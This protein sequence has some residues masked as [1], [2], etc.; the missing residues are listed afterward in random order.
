MGVSVRQTHGSPQTALRAHNQRS[1]ILPASQPIHQWTPSRLAR[2]LL[3]ILA[4]VGLVLSPVPVEAKRDYFRSG[5]PVVVAAEPDAAQAGMNVLKRGGS[6]IDAAVAVQ[7]ALSLLEPQSSGIGGGAFLLYYDARSGKVTAYNG[8]ETA[9]A[10]ADGN[11][12]MDNDGRPLSFASAVV[13]GRATGVPGAMFMLERAHRDHGRLPWRSLF[14]DSI[15][16]AEQGFHVPPRLAR[17]LHSGPFP[18]LRSSD[19]QR[20]F[21]NGKGGFVRTGDLLKNPEYGRTLRDIAR[22][23]MV[24]FRE[25]PLAQEIVD[26]LSEAPLPSGMR[27]SDLQSYQP[28]VDEAACRTYRIHVVCVPPSP[29]GGVSVLQGLQLLERFPI[30]S[31]GKD[32]PRSWA[33]FIE[34]LRLMYADRDQYVGDPDFVSVPMEG[35]LDPSYIAARAAM[36]T[37]GKASPVPKPGI[38]TGAPKLLLDKTLEPG[39]TTHFVVIDRYGNAVSMTTT[40]ESLFGTGRM[41]GG[42]FLNN[43]LTDFSFSPMAADGL[44]AANAV[45]PGKRPRSAMSPI[46]VFDRSG[47]LQ[48]L[49][50]SPG[51]PAIIS[52]NLKALIGI[53]DWQLSMQ[54]AIDL[55]N[56]VAR[57]ESIRIEARR[58]DPAIR[59]SLVAMGYVLTEVQ[60]EESGLN[61][62][63]RQ[64]DGTFD[65][66]VDPRRNGV[67]VNH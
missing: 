61:G 54:E 30:N 51:G 41:A 25:G 27:L 64:P 44:R 14:A 37:P 34:T 58:M 16:L 9:P 65:G 5:G 57:G 13:S 12:L 56:V 33:V 38:P 49:V 21:G 7:A 36:I 6:A 4:S 52:Y 17:A 24:V 48:A 42:F 20:Y 59:S 28:L 47:R 55:P 35:L 63:L 67:V 50:G 2:N 40:V 62:L 11:L 1:T 66:G 39:G 26:K 3:T 53:L 23:G 60:G 19:L 18:Q 45:E 46:M 31:W 15:K 29:T 8:R 43:Q 10:S 32:D 22:R